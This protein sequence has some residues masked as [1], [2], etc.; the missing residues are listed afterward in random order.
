MKTVMC[1]MLLALVLSACSM[2]SKEPVTRGDESV[3]EAE[4]NTKAVPLDLSIP[5]VSENE[6]DVQFAEQAG[7]LPDMF[8]EKE[9]EKRVS[10]SAAPSLKPG[11]ELLDMPEIDGAS[12]SVEV[13]ID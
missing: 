4:N 8:K 11:E 9:K 2:D 1:L 13:K 6:Y 3:L 5:A 7:N 10:V 12:V